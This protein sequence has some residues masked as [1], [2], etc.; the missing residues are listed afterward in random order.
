MRL[1]ASLVSSAGSAPGSHAASPCGSAPEVDRE[2]RYAASDDETTATSYFTVSLSSAEVPAQASPGIDLTVADPLE[3]GVEPQVPEEAPLGAEQGGSL[4]VDESAMD[5]Q[6][7]ERFQELVRKT[8]SHIL[9]RPPPRR[10]R[11]PPRTAASALPGERPRP[12]A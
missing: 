9:P 6:V 7:V 3:S 11:H 1:E 4:A 12:P 2:D 8:P 10:R 5:A